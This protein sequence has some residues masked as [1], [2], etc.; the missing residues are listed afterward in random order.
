MKTELCVNC[1]KLVE[2]SNNFHY[3]ETRRH[4]GLEYTV[5]LKFYT[6]FKCNECEEV[7]HTKHSERQ[8][9]RELKN[10][11][12]LLQAE[13]IRAG[14]EKTGYSQKGFAEL[15]GIAEEVVSRWVNHRQIQS[16]S[17]DNFMR[18][19]FSFPEVRRALALWKTEGVS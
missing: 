14:L 4:D 5:E 11:I 19:F 18:V 1:M 12:G 17:S 15:T 13:E 10:V 6:G 16:R 7:H 8:I 2:M 3:K 9:I